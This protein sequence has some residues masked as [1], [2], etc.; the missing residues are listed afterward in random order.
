MTDQLPPLLTQIVPPSQ[1]APAA[2]S[3]VPASAAQI[4]AKQESVDEEPYTIKCICNFSDDDGN[5]I[6]CEK[7]DTWQHIECFYPDNVEDALREDFTHFCAECKPRA[8]DRQKARERQT[9]RLFV[10]DFGEEETAD[11]KQKRSPSKSH[12]KKPKPTDLQLAGPPASTNEQAKHNNT[13][14]HDPSHPAKKSKS[15]HKASHSVSSQGPKRSP[16]SSAHNH[17]GHPPSPATTPPDLPRDLETH[18]YL[19][20]FRSF[21]DDG[22]V[23]FVETNSFVRLEVSNT[24]SVWLRDSEKMRAET[25]HEYGDVYQKFPENIDAIKREPQVEHKKI[26]LAPDIVVRWQFLTAPSPIDKDVPLMELNGQIGFQKDYCANPENKWDELTTPLPFVF[27]HPMLPLYID[28]RTEGSR[29]RFV[30]RSCRPNAVLDTYLSEGS[31]Y[32]FWLVSDRPIAAKEQITIPWDFRFP[33]KNKPRMLR[34]LGLSDEDT[35]APPV[36]PEI[37]DLEYLRIAQWLHNVLSEYGGCACDRG[38]DCAFAQFHRNYSGGGT[39][40]RAASNNKK[41]SRKTKTQHALSPTSTGHATNSRAP[42]E[43]HSEDVPDV[44]GRSQ[45]GSVR[46][47][48]PSRDMTPA[49]QGSFD[50]LGILTEPTDRDKRKVAMVEDTFRRMEQQQQPAR[51]KKRTSDGSGSSKTKSSSRGSGTNN[52]AGGLPNGVVE[53]R[54]ID[55]STSRSGSNSPSTAASPRMPD[56]HAHKPPAASRHTSVPA[57]SRHASVAPRSN[58]R[59]VAVQTDAVEGEWYSNTS[60]AARPKPKRKIISLSK[61]LLNNRHQQRLDE[62]RRRT[63]QASTCPMDLDPV[64]AEQKQITDAERSGERTSSLAGSEDTEMTDAPPGSA[65]E[66]KPPQVQPIAAP[67]T[68]RSPDLRVQMP[69]TPVFGNL[70]STTP[71]LITPSSGGSLAQSPFSAS[72]MPSL[73]GPPPLVNG[74][75]AHPSPVKKKMSLSDYKSRMS[76]AQAARPTV[77]TTALK[78]ST[79]GADEP[80]SATS[81]ETPLT[82]ES[83]SS[84]KASEMGPTVNGVDQP[85]SSA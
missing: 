40:A 21:Y 37:D 65:V 9:A 11:K 81:L 45:S 29:A 57:S 48:P 26:S 3:S 50:M 35:A 66:M 36:E 23:H 5:T 31:E 28:T 44:D 32:H 63:S 49:R 18:N 76:K 47:K 14:G 67:R 79:P 80:K 75:G 20:A 55:A 52:P 10:V 43:G 84:E 27:F 4:S 60:P 22:H 77:G 13:S 74:V 34:I 72:S 42:S 58:Y 2:A 68:N 46:S 70:T 16:P 82:A 69:P 19:P 12:K 39:H 56:A 85:A 41:K 53:R 78:P 25:G 33:A 24:M 6:Y 73:F 17:R 38:R 51:K 1:T 15:S 59:D 64:G 30:R 62:E 54:H 61:R 71:T 7:C 8:L 83:P